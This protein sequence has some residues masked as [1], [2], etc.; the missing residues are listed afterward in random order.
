MFLTHDNNLKWKKIGWGAAITAALVALGIAWYDKWL[1]LFMRNFDCGLWRAFDMLFSAKI[2]LIATALVLVLFYIKK[3]YLS[4]WDFRRP[5]GRFS[6]KAFCADFWNKIRG[7]NAFFIFTSVVAA[8][9]IVGILK[10]FIGRARPILFE[11]VEFTG[12]FPPSTEWVFNS[13]PSGHT[14]ISFAGL[15]M[16]GMLAPRYKVLTWGLAIL[17]GASRVAFGAHWPTDVILGAFIGMVIADIVKWALVK[18]NK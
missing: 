13:M 7:S 3:A 15:V 14:T 10:I 12:F 11:A 9:V 18:L 5:N 6:F 17:I 1:Y 16:I 4:G 8:G 2:W